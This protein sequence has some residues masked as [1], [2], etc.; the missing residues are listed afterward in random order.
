MSGPSDTT[1]R[2]AELFLLEAWVDDNPGSR[3]FLKLARAYHQD[4]RLA[5]AEE[6]LQKGLVLHP[7]EIEARE[8]LARVMEDQGNQEGALTQLTLA[9]REIGRH[10]VVYERL[11]G[12]WELRGMISEA[13]QARQLAKGLSLD[14]AQA[15]LSDLGQDT[16]TM[17]EIYA[18]QGHLEQAAAIYRKILAKKP[19]DTEIKNRL[20]QL[21]SAEPS[22]APPSAPEPVPPPAQE[23]V[24]SRLEALKQAAQKRM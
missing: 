18:E 9:A 1:G 19:G 5:E 4:G 23:P 22:P 10:A 6:V 14:P 20:D 17:A 3:L 13:E 16:V 21:T 2:Q 11:A 8:L 7:S 12:I 15:T 24:T